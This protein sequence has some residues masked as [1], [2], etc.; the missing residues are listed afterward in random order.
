MWNYNPKKHGKHAPARNLVVSD[1]AEHQPP[2]PAV[3]HYRHT[4]FSTKTKDGQV[5]SS[6][7]HRTLTLPA[8][9]SQLPVMDKDLY[10]SIAELSSGSFLDPDYAPS[11]EVQGGE[12]EESTTRAS[13]LLGIGLISTIVSPSLTNVTHQDHPLL[14]WSQLRSE[15]L[16]EILKLDAF[17]TE[18]NDACEACKTNLGLFRCLSCVDTRHLCHTCIVAGHKGLPLHKIEVRQ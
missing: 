11:A 1:G 14:V 12:E 15:F 13:R 7:C 3:E 18:D 8:L 17:E 6:T 9:E 10:P 4:H 2:A 16:D 5:R